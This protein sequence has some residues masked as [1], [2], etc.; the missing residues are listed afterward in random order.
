M[1]N[2]GISKIHDHIQ[3]MI[4]IPNPNQEPPAS[5]KAPNQDLRDTDVL[6]TFKIN[7]VSQNF[8][9]RYIKTRDHIQIIIKIQNPN[10]EPPASSKPQYQD[11]KDMDVLC[12]F[13]I[14]IESQNSEYGCT[15][16]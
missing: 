2:M 6:C 7:I 4:K 8:D 14:K 1:L 16:D 15:K 12:I 5:T 11:L 9:H 13:K 3:I 10:L